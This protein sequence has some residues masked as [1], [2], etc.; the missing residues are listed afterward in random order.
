MSFRRS[1]RPERR[2]WT[3]A[4]GYRNRP[5]TTCFSFDAPERILGGLKTGDFDANGCSIT[6]SMAATTSHL[7]DQLHR[8]IKVSA[9]SLSG[10]LRADSLTARDARLNA[11]PCY[12]S[13]TFNW[14]VT[15]WLK[16]RATENAVGG[17]T[18]FREERGSPMLSHG[19]KKS[20]STMFAWMRNG[21][22]IRDW[23]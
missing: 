16:N 2:A 13:A 5:R 9:S 17:T 20:S 6:R 11:T 4:T 3:S 19:S 14:E 7:N 1:A 10:L 8:L 23:S 21:W 18:D 15:S 22:P 12:E